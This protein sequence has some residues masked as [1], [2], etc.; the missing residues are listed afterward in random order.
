MISSKGVQNVPGLGGFISATGVM[1]IKKSTIDYYTP[2]NQP[3]TQYETVQELLR[4]SEQATRE[5]G[6]FTH[7]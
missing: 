3:I 1:P 5:V 2:I 4:R 6:H 7:V